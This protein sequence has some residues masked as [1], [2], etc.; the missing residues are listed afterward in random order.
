MG[1]VGSVLCLRVLMWD[2]SCGIWGMGLCV[3]HGFKGCWVHVLCCVK[4]A[5]VA[6]FLGCLLVGGLGCL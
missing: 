6:G 3:L 5:E 2:D 1:Y 4:G